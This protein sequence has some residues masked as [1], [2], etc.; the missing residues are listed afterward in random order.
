VA[1]FYYLLIA[2]DRHTFF[3]NGKRIKISCFQKHIMKTAWNTF[4]SCLM[5]H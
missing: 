2:A 1:E 3:G 5:S 4:W